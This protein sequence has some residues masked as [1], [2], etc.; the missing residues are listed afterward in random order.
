MGGYRAVFDENVLL[1]LL[2][3]RSRYVFLRLFCLVYFILKLSYWAAGET[4]LISMRD[5]ILPPLSSIL[6]S[7][8]LLSGVKWFRTDVS[9]VP[10]GPIFKGQA[11][12]E[13]ED[14][15]TL[16]DETYR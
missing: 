7:S 12:E 4:A 2:S 3:S 9:E 6:P 16:E 8:G 13:Q 10:I 15:L 5:R 14:S 11:V 1:V